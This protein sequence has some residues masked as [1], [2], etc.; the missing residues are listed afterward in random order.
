MHRYLPPG[1]EEG[2]PITD[3]LSNAQPLAVD[4]P[5]AR[6]DADGAE[7]VE[8]SPFEKY[9]PLL[10]VGISSGTRTRSGRAKKK[11][12]LAIRFVKKY[13]QYAK[14]KPA[15][16]L[17]KGAADHI[18]TVYAELR[19]EATGAGVRRVCAI[20]YGVVNCFAYSHQDVTAYSSNIGDTHPSRDCSCE[21]SP[22]T[23]SYRRRCQGGRS[24]PPLRPL[25]GSCQTQENEKE[26]EATS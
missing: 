12:V 1:V 11:E 20:I 15:P 13:V 8:T 4:G 21:S 5:A 22:L 25:Q 14:S 18:V 7:G 26:Q 17:T 19:N 2:T 9:D 3:S 6:G 16:V 10:H 23:Q 24:N